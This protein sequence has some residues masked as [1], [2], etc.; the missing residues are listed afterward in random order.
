MNNTLVNMR[1]VI[2]QWYFCRNENLTRYNT[3]P[4][5]RSLSASVVSVVNGSQSLLM[6]EEPHGNV[7]IVHG[8]T[9]QDTRTLDPCRSVRWT[10]V[11]T[12]KWG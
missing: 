5:S 10:C 8:L 12:Q 7:T 4:T 9:T 1:F 2:D 6:F 11:G 3:A